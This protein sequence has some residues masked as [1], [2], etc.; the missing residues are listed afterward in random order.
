[1]ENQIAMRFVA[2]SLVAVGLSCALPL[3]AGAAHPRPQ[4]LLAIAYHSE[5]D[6]GRAL[7]DGRADVVRK[8]PGLHVAEVRPRV[9]G[10]AVAARRVLQGAP[11]ELGVSR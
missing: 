6:L 2:A 8:L 11:V 10:F 4:A 9:D 7:A 1:M 5:A 3:G